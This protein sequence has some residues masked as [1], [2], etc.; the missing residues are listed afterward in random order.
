MFRL[1]L[2]SG[3]Y[4]VE[5]AQNGIG[6]LI[7]IRDI[8]PDVVVTD[9][10]MPQM[11]GP[12]LIRRIRSDARAAG[13]SILAVTGHPEARERAAGADAFL[14][15]PFDRSELLQAVGSLLDHEP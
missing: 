10:V 15:K 9:L 4:L 2:E 6:A 7:L 14:E 11:D 1:I 5:E 13:V 12:E 3:G 8:P